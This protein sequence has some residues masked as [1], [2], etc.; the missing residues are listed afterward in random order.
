MNLHGCGMNFLKSKNILL[1][2][3]IWGSFFCVVV[4]CQKGQANQEAEPFKEVRDL[5]C[6]DHTRR[7]EVTNTSY[8]EYYCV[9]MDGR[10]GLWLEF[11][12]NG[13]LRT[14]ANYVKDKLNGAWTSYH[15]NGQIDTEGLMEN[16]V[17]TGKWTQYYVNGKLRSVKHYEN[18]RLHGGVELYYNTGT[19][20]AS[21]D[22]VND[23]EEG[24]WKVYTPKGELARECRLEHGEEKECQI[25]IKDFQ[26]TSKFYPSKE[27]GAL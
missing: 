5:K 15:P 17:R 10:T 20:M 24:P 9:G 3:V 25:F 21:G 2:I 8:P 7:V 11:D 16:D 1:F 26:P 23:Y 22:Y 12:V 13:R 6:P 19:I 27:R 14:R 18:N 4:G